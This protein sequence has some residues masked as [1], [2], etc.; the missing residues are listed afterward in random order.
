[1]LQKIDSI[2]FFWNV[3][4]FFRDLCHSAH[5]RT[6]PPSR[7]FGMSSR[8][9]G[10]CAIRHTSRGT[11]SRSFGIC[12]CGTHPAGLHP[13]LS[14]IC[15]CGTHPGPA[16]RGALAT[17]RPSPGFQASLKPGDGLDVAER[18]GFEPVSRFR[19]LHAFQACLLSHSSIFPYCTLKGVSGCK[20]TFFID[21]LQFPCE[22]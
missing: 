1:M 7:S 14:G 8:S 6:G 21:I 5:I 3:I 18:T 4:P 11:S 17:S 9:F 12:A 19:R 15:A 13:V 20:Y 22:S 2:P 10:I 16:R